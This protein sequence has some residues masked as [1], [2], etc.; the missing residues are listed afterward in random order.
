MRVMM[1]RRP[2]GAVTVTYSGE[3][4]ALCDLDERANCLA[5]HLCPL[6]WA[7]QRAPGLAGSA[8]WTWWLP[9]RA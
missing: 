9:S 3:Q 5:Q 2:A 4:P 7:P 8:G 6:A 1:Q